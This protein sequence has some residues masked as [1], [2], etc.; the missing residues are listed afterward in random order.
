MEKLLAIGVG[1]FLGAVARYGI[2]GWV[3]SRTG[4][5]FPAGT[6]IVNVLGCLVIGSL[7]TLFETR[8]MFGP[9]MRTFLAVGVLG[10]FTT[11]STLGYETLELV[12]SGALPAAAA[13]LAGNFAIGLSAV[14]LGRVAVRLALG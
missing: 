14:W 8:P 12:R 4:S 1:G 13:F 6:L 7:M 3:Q 9:Q 11:F 10:S 2:S 5:V